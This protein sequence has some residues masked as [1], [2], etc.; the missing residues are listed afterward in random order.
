VAVTIEQ[1][2]EVLSSIR[3][4][5]EPSF[6]V[7]Y[8]PDFPDIAKVLMASH[9]FSALCKTQFI[10]FALALFG[11][12]NAEEVNKEL[13]S[14]SSRQGMLV[15]FYAGFQ[16]GKRESQISELEKMRNA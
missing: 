8:G 2:N 14:I 4:Y 9:D 6:G 11:N 7:K 16:L 1:V 10:M 12:K 15:A 13:D 3:K 5:E